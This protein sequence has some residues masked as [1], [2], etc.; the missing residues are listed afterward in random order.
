[1]PAD[2]EIHVR[3]KDGTSRDIYMYV[4]EENPNNFF[5]WI[6]GEPELITVQHFVIDKFLK[7]KSDLLAAPVISPGPEL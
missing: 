2:R 1:E 4:R 5:A 7:K 3:Y 6:E